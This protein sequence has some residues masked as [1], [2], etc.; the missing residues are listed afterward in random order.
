MQDTKPIHVGTP[1]KFTGYP[2]Y[3]QGLTGYISKLSNSDPYSFHITFKDGTW[4]VT[5][6]FQVE[7]L[8]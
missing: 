4:M 8:E 5:D 1:V 6:I 7:I 3:K 2:S